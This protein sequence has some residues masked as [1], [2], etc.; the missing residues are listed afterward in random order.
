MPP[1]SGARGGERFLSLPAFSWPACATLSGKWIRENCGIP[2]DAGRA[3][4]DSPLAQWKG[5]YFYAHVGIMENQEFDVNF[6]AC[7]NGISFVFPMEHW[8]S[9][10]NLFRSAWQSPDVMQAWDT[11]ALEYGEM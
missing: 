11:L 7:D 9:I 2:K 1:R 6:C 8:K 5:H 3:R 10:Q 4:F